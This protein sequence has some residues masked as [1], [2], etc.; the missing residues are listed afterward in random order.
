MLQDKLSICDASV[1]F[2]NDGIIDIKGR[3]SKTDSGGI[4]ETDRKNTSPVSPMLTKELGWNVENTSPMLLNAATTIPNW[5]PI[6]SRYKT[7]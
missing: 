5:N 4:Y 7:G 2:I 6:R 3:T 1:D